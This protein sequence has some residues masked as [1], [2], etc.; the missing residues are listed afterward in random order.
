[1]IITGGLCSLIFW[2]LVIY[3]LYKLITNVNKQD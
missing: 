1:M 2:I 3:L